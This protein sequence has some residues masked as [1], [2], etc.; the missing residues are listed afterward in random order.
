MAPQ[1]VMGNT[2][3]NPDVVI[4]GAGIAGLGAAKTLH[5]KGVSFLVVEANNRIGGRVHTNNKIFGCRLILMHTG[6]G[7]RPGIR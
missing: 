5:S 6:W 1:I 3:T 4:I 2:V 7:L